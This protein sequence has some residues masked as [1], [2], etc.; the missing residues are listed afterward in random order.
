MADNDNEPFS[1]DKLMELVDGAA[2]V[3]H[4]MTRAQ[5]DYLTTIGVTLPGDIVIDDDEFEDY[6][7]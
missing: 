4:Y 6:E 1:M 5:Y 3:R 7:G 2:P